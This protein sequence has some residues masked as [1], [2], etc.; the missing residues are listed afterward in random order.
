MVAVVTFG[1][2]MT[3]KMSSFKIAIAAGVLVGLYAI[4]DSYKNSSAA[5]GQS[6]SLI[7]PNVVCVDGLAYKVTGVGLFDS[8]EGLSQ[9]RDT[10]GSAV[11]CVKKADFK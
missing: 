9:V 8:G 11:S 1:A 6:G 5:V 4:L 3:F 10:N 7:G 2:M